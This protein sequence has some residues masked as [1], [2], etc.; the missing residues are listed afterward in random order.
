MQ[1]VRSQALAEQQAA[2]EIVDAAIAEEQDDPTIVTA[3]PAQE[4]TVSAPTRDSP[5]AGGQT[6]QL[7][8]AVTAQKAELPP[9]SSKPEVS[10]SSSG[11][12]TPPGLSLQHVEVDDDAND[13]PDFAASE[14][15]REDDSDANSISPEHCQC[16]R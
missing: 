4:Q 2:S 3:A 14:S 6:S 16:W 7:P 1:I 13:A 12:A 15:E 9:A 8:S 10:A 5:T 11:A